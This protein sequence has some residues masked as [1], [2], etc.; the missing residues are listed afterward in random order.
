MQ[1]GALVYLLTAA[2]GE[3]L[4]GLLQQGQLALGAL[5]LGELF[6]DDFIDHGAGGVG[7]GLYFYQAFDVVQR[8]IEFAAA[9]DKD[10]GI[11]VARL[12]MAIAVAGALRRFE[13]ANLLIIANGFRIYLG[14]RRKF[15]DFHIDLP[16]AVT[17]SIGSIIY[18][19]PE[20]QVIRYV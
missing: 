17:F 20:G 3:G 18:S 4:Q 5:Y 12:V 11:Y 16:V 10:Q 9:A 13:Q 14:F 2:G 7:V 19:C 8:D 1:N 15:A 6:G